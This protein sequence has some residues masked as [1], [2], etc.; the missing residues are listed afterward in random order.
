MMTLTLKQIMAIKLGINSK[1]INTSYSISY[2][3]LQCEGSCTG[4]C[5]QSCSG[6][7]YGANKLIGAR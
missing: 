6:G 3:C 2:S 1:P 4:G 7:C 5:H